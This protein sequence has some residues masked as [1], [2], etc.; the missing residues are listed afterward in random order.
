[1]ATILIGYA[2]LIVEFAA[3]TLTV[4]EPELGAAIVLGLKVTATP[5]GRSTAERAIELLNPP[6]IAVAIDAFP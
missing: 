1:V 2:P 3:F 4:D 5:G 6:K